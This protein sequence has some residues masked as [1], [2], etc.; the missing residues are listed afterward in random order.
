[1]MKRSMRI[2]CLAALAA[3]VP[4]APALAGQLEHSWEVGPWVSYTVFDN[5]FQLEDELGVGGHVGYNFPH[6]HELE[7]TADRVEPDVDES[8]RRVFGNLDV[9]IWTWTLGYVYNFNPK[10][11]IVPFLT[12]GLG[13]AHV[14][15]EDNDESDMTFHLG[16][17]VRFF[18]NDRFQVRLDG[19]Y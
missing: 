3:V 17:G 16:G 19:R 12:T 6:G 13:S 7:I 9:T 4:A 14:D 1:C 2:V 8:V 18:V 10:K 5:D 15:I 11:D